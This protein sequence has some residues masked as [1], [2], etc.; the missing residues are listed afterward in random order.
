MTKYTELTEKITNLSKEVQEAQQEL[1]EYLDTVTEINESSDLGE[2]VF[3]SVS[4]DMQD[5]DNKQVI[6]FTTEHD[7]AVPLSVE[8]LNKAMQ[9]IAGLNTPLFRYNQG[10]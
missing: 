10:E 9:F 2:G 8:Q 7:D 1:G 4:F 3:V 6:T 5:T